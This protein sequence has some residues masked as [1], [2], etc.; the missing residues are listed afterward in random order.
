MLFCSLVIFQREGTM[1]FKLRFFVMNYQDFLRTFE[2]NN[3]VSVD[4]ETQVP[5]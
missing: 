5:I 2:V 4:F 1:V 3:F